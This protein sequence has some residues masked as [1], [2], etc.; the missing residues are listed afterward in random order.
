MPF[1]SK[2]IIVSSL[3][4][5]KKTTAGEQDAPPGSPAAE[6]LEKVQRE[7]AEAG[8]SRS[9]R[10]QAL[11]R[12]VKR[13]HPDQNSGKDTVCLEKVRGN[14]MG[15]D[16][17][18]FVLFFYVFCLIVVRIVSCNC[19]LYLLVV[20]LPDGS[21]EYSCSWSLLLFDTFEVSWR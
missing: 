6:I 17:F 1:P 4:L 20:F 8:S 3:F 13:L 11:R 14:G 15:K 9:A 5:K 19:F 2:K 7:L 21:I 16:M 18:F 12:L 10:R